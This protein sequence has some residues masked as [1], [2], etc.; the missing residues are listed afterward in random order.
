MLALESSRWK[1]LTHAYGAAADVPELIRAIEAERSPDFTDGGAWFEVYSSLYH[2][3]SMYPATYAAFPNLVRVANSGTLPQR[4][5][6]L[7]LAGEMRIFGHVDSPVPR[8]LIPDFEA[9]MDEIKRSS[10]E[11]VKEAWNANEEWTTHGDLLQ[12]FGGLRH[13]TSGYV[14][15]LNYLVRENWSV[16]AACPACGNVMV[17]EL[18]DPFVSTVQISSGKLN[19]TTSRM[20]LVDRDGYPAA[21]AKGE[22]FIASGRSDWELAETPLVLSSLAA[23]LGDTEL[24]FRVLDLG[25]RVE[26]AYCGH[27]FVLAD[28]LSPL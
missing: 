28:S 11:T 5:A 1:K 18:R 8:D 26:C 22:A 25:T 14:V 7:C 12:A 27:R 3:H 13:P 6:I 2:Q 17:G 23:A 20:V 10:L 19:R 9:A 16:E 15:Q 24:A 21:H 4:T